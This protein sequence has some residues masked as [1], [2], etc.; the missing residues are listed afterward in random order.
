MKEMYRVLKRPVLSEKA[1]AVRDEELKYYFEVEMAANKMDIRQAVE[2][3]F[4]VKVKKIN[5]EIVRGKFRR[6]GRTFGQKPSWKKACVT[7][8]EGFSIDLF[9]GV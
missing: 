9:E 3:I 7:L 8:Q 6:V 4:S 2:K 1:D 5:T